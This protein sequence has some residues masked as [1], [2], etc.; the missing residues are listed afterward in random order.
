MTQLGLKWKI[1][2]LNCTAKIMIPHN[3]RWKSGRTMLC[4]CRKIYIDTYLHYNMLCLFA[5]ISYQQPTQH[6]LLSFLLSKIS[7]LDTFLP[8][9]IYSF[10]FWW[11]YYENVLQWDKAARKVK[12]CR[13]HLY[14]VF[15][16]VQLAETQSGAVTAWP[17]AGEGKWDG[18]Y[19]LDIKCLL[20]EGI[21]SDCWMTI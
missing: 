8:S 17:G 18:C 2:A 20:G 9:G 19:S 12:N 6:N 13:V 7:S 5:C 3:G 21:I 4:I 10:P 11:G 15:E 16:I 14:E 1:M